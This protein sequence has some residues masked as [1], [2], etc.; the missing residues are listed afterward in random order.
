[1]IQIQIDKKSK[2]PLY[3][4]IRDDIKTA[5][6]KGDLK[7]GDR[8]PTVADLA[9]QAGVTQATIRRAMEDLARDGLIHSHVGRG[10]FVG[11]DAGG[12]AAGGSD[13]NR[14]MGPVPSLRAAWR[15]RQGVSKG[16]C[17]LMTA[18]CRPGIRDFSKGVPE[19]G[20]MAPG[21]WEKMVGIAVKKAGSEALA[22]GDL[23]GLPALR[24]A[25]AKR[26]AAK[27][28][29]ISPDQVLITIGAQQGICIA[30]LDAA[31]QG[32]RVWI[33]A[34]G[35]QGTMD[36]FAGHGNL[37]ETFS[38]AGGNLTLPAETS[39][40]ETNL[41]C[42]CPDFQ[43]PTGESMDNGLRRAVADWTGQNSGMVLSD[44]IYQDLR[45]EGKAP[46]PMI[47]FLGQNRTIVVS[48]LSKS[49]APGLRVGWMV[50][51]PERIAEFRRLKRLMAQTGPPLMESIALAFLTSGAY[52]EH[53]E[54]I[55]R[56][57]RARRDTMV[58]CLEQLMPEGVSWTCPQGG[59]AL[60][61]TLPPGYSSVALLISIL[62]KGISLVPGPV[63]DR[64][65]RY[66]NAFRLSWA[67]TGERE[68][69]EGIEILA[70]AVK[71]LL[72]RPPG[73]SGLSGLGSFRQK[74]G[75]HG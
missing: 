5:I 18:A 14:A 58:S 12:A 1:M 13:R 16:L 19:P 37:V 21:V 65:Q 68:I 35:F 74:E 60:W 4:Q 38:T 66:V 23:G 33:E 17:D 44:V 3:A 72:R 7:D 46:E 43:N 26:H 11:S 32:R 50:A 30:A 52:D 54:A 63:F 48:S 61:V 29:H 15:L 51:S 39:S 57:Y 64:D 45:F 28:V 24:E 71:E 75:G 59:F 47:N 40:A 6:S 62:D 34:P 70:D 36:A 53:L 2:C 69:S 9:G 22:Y 42:L 55:R 31:E 56:I 10:T 41:L 49:L 27:G 8:L 20:L 73:D 25:V 67:W